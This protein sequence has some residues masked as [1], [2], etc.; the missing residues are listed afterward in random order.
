MADGAEDDRG[1]QAGG[2]PGGGATDA[3]AG[4]AAQSADGGTAA[5]PAEAGTTE[6]QVLDMGGSAEPKGDAG[7]D[8]ET[9]RLRD[10][11][12][13]VQPRHD[14]MATS[15]KHVRELHP[16]LF[17][18]EGNFTGKPAAGATDDGVLNMGGPTADA[19][20][21]AAPAT[22]TRQRGGIEPV[23]YDGAQAGW[24]QLNDES[25]SQIAEGQNVVGPVVGIIDA[26]LQSKGVDLDQLARAGTGGMTEEQVSRMIATGARSEVVAYDREVTGF[27]DRVSAMG[28]QFGPEFLAMSVKFSD[29]PQMSME[30]SLGRICQETGERDP[31]FAVLKH[32]KCGPAAHAALVQ[33]QAQAMA[34][35]MVRRGAGPQLM[36][37]GSGLPGGLPPT[38]D[39][40]SFGGGHKPLKR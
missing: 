11:L 30:K 29:S 6:A 5:A 32:P 34:D 26:Y 3:G 21:A 25:Y 15:M 17:D 23:R 4:A 22:E 24:Q 10:K 39:F 13:Q 19:G 12:K 14:A 38:D 20:Q 36:P 40:K 16:E 37:G 2:D 27:E 8:D 35:D 31:Y 28:E 1:T 9:A 18:G 7:A 33:R